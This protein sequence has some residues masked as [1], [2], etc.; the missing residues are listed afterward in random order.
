MPLARDHITAASRRMLPTYPVLLFVVGLSFA[1]D[2]DRALAGS[3]GLRFADERIPLQVWGGLALTLAALLMVALAIPR[4]GRRLYQ[5]VL[6]A[7]IVWLGLWS[8]ALLW[9]ALRGQSSWSAWAWPA[10]G[11]RACWATLLSL[12]VHER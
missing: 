5:L 8:L 3:S 12:E 6:G 1:F 10:F 11:A 9:A 7:A 4:G 2:T